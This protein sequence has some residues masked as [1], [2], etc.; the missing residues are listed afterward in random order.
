MHGTVANTSWLFMGKLPRK[1]FLKFGA[2]LGRKHSLKC[3]IITALIACYIA[4]LS[5]AIDYSHK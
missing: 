1:F 5:A 2:S 4:N 3:Y